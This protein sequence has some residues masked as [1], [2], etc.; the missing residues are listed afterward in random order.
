MSLRR[1]FKELACLFKTTCFPR[2]CS[3]LDPTDAIRQNYTGR[4]SLVRENEWINQY[5]NVDRC[6]CFH[7]RNASYFIQIL[8][9]LFINKILTKLSQGLRGF[10]FRKL[11]NHNFGTYAL[12][13]LVTKLKKLVSFGTVSIANIKPV[14]SQKRKGLIFSGCKH[15]VSCDT[16]SKNLQIFW[17]A[18]SEE[19]SF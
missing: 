2:R 10:S 7:F 13:S 16:L 18:E 6:Y 1:I 15:F 8:T 14:L 5:R 17:F 19:S 4:N 11:N 3:L 9:S 12:N